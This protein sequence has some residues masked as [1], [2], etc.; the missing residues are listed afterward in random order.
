MADFPQDKKEFLESLTIEYNKKL[1]DEKK[2]KMLGSITSKM[3]SGITR[4]LIKAS[5][6]GV[7]LTILKR[8]LE[9]VGKQNAIEIMKAFDLKGDKLA[10]ASEVMKI[11]ALLLG[12]DMQVVG[13]ETVVKDC[14]QCRLA[15]EESE[16][17]FTKICFDYGSGVVHAVLGDGY[18]LVEDKCIARGDDY[19]SYSIKKK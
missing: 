8:E 14:P 13:N 18:E 2:A 1:T 12:L 4:Q 7:T 9:E 6:Y 15:K 10:I 5:G 11:S 16:P 3:L 17:A 19:C